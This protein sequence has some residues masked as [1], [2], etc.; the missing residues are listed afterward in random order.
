MTTATK[1]NGRIKA[2]SVVKPGETRVDDTFSTNEAERRLRLDSVPTPVANSLRWESRP[3]LSEG[4][5]AR[6]FE[7]RGPH[8]RFYVCVS[9]IPNGTPQT[10]YPFEVLIAGEGPRTLNALAKSLSMDM[11]SRDRAWLKAKLDAIADTDGEPF[12]MVMPNGVPVIMKSET[13]AFARLVSYQCEQLGAFNDENIV[14]TPLMD[15]L[16]SRKEPRTTADGSLAWY[17]DIN[18]PQTKD[19]FRLFLPELQLPDGRMRPFS[20]WFDGDYPR[21]LTGLAKS[22]SYDLRVNDVDW[23]VRKLRQLV[24]ITEPQGDFRAQV[25]GTEKS[26]VYPSTIAY[27]ATLILH[28]FRMRGLLDE[29][30]SVTGGRSNALHLVGGSTVDLSEKPTATDA[31][32]ECGAIGATRNEGGCRTCGVCGHSACAG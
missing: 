4:N 10:G 14:A 12:Q 8:N 26:A 28:R 19:K 18:N 23:A 31:C 32:P 1:I 11:R 13:A 16:M 22:L 5:P 3:E 27:V 2:Y 24:D 20:V 6:V 30:Y 15:A 21:S 25:P 7:I 9:Y 29:H 17:A